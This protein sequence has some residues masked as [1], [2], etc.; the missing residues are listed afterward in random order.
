MWGCGVDIGEEEGWTGQ[1]PEA[2]L[3]DPE[4]GLLEETGSA[5]LAAAV[6]L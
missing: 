2:E 5:F 3:L 1:H 6:L 4:N